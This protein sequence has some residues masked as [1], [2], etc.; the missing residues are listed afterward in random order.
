MPEID[1]KKMAAVGRK[2]RACKG[3][4]NGGPAAV[5]RTNPVAL[6]KNKAHL[7]PVNKGKPFSLA[8]FDELVH[9]LQ[10][11]QIELEMQNEELRRSQEA[12]MVSQSKYMNLYDFAPVGYLTI[13]RN[14]QIIEANL[15]AAG[16]L[17][18]ERRLLLRTPFHLFLAEDSD[19]RVLSLHFGQVLK[20]QGRCVC[21]VRIKR[22]KAAPFYAQLQTIAAEDGTGGYPS[23]FRVTVSDIT[24]SKMVGELERS[25]DQLRDLT[26]YI[27]SVREEERTRISR[28]LHDELGQL[29]TGLH[30]DLSVLKKKCG[31]DRELSE[32]VKAMC[33]TIGR[34]IKTVQHVSAELRPSILDHLGLGAAIEWQS[35]EFTK[36][37]GMPCNVHLSEGPLP[38]G[39]AASSALFRIFQETMTNV[40]R[41]AGAKKVEV[42]LLRE[43]NFATLEIND[44]GK[45]IPEKKAAS[46]KSFGLL[47]IRERADHFGGTVMIRGVPNMGTTVTVKIPLGD[48]AEDIGTAAVLGARP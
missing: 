15:T 43:G 35:Q 48:A 42:S 25:K 1:N 20:T 12:L 13:D 6:L 26:A 2:R 21:E 47:G 9:E 24:D 45:G 30:M 46:P 5:L 10:T 8:Q 18:M 44:D 41:H 3:N 40:A 29:L 16:L 34:A 11:H 36:R 32:R 17:G 22:R 28:E 37:W 27:Q 4:R 19:R 39:K 31:D 33:K 38:L 14:G 7:P 23:C